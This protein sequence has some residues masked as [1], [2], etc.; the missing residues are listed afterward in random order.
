MTRDESYET[1]EH[2]QNQKLGGDSKESQCEIEAGKSVWS[3]LADKGVS[4]C[5]MSTNKS[6]GTA[7]MA[8]S[9]QVRVWKAGT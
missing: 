9:E 8:L 4:V 2:K 7:M 3:G 6:R 5:A 1:E